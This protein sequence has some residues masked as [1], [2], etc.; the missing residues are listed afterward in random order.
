MNDQKLAAEIARIIEA[1]INRHLND[2]ML[3][4][5]FKLFF[6][7]FK[8]SRPQLINQAR[9]MLKED[10]SQRFNKI[11][12]FDQ[13]LFINEDRFL[14][15]G[16]LLMKK[17]YNIGIR[18]LK[19]DL[20]IVLAFKALRSQE[21]QWQIYEHILDQTQNVAEEILKTQLITKG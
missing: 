19:K 7:L 14:E 21:L 18:L 1:G 9:S 10:I 16:N 2:S 6:N 5:P 3:Y 17:C 11:K 8:K 15:A 20:T 4:S 12:N 13:N